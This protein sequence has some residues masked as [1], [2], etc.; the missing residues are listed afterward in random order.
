MKLQTSSA[1][2]EDRSSEDADS[3]S[4]DISIHKTYSK[5][6]PITAAEKIKHQDT[7][8][9]NREENVKGRSTECR[10]PS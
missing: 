10:Y 2:T 9:N 5:H 6:N 3:A 4:L 7:K 1:Q 8:N